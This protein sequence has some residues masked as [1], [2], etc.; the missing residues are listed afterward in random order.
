MIEKIF[1]SPKVPEYIKLSIINK[2]TE[3]TNTILGTEQGGL[4]ILISLG[5][6]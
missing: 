3:V 6:T 1:T 4:L 2:T 5:G